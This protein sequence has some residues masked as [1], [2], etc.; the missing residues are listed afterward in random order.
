MEIR[1]V[2][3][4]FFHGDGETDRRA[5]IQTD[6]TR[7]IVAFRNFANAPKKGEIRKY[8]DERK[9]GTKERRKKEIRKASNVQKIKFL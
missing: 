1:P 4:E 5:E 3:D 6:I 2:V 8:K 7:Q 9:E